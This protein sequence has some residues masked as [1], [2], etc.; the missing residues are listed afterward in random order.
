[1]YPDLV[2]TDEPAQGGEPCRVCT[3]TEWTSPGGRGYARRLWA[4]VRGGYVLSLST[5]VTN[6]GRTESVGNRLKEHVKNCENYSV[7]VVNVY[8]A[9]SLLA[10]YSPG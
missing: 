3:H 6:V 10:T 8:M 7:D 1:M 9:K 4:G 2:F 5:G